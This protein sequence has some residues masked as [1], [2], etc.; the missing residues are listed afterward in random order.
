MSNSN[1][2]NQYNTYARA[3]GGNGYYNPSDQAQEYQSSDYADY[4]GTTFNNSSPNDSPQLYDAGMYNQ[5]PYSGGHGH[6]HGHG[7]QGLQNGHGRVNSGGSRRGPMSAYHLWQHQHEQNMRQQHAAQQM[8]QQY[9]Q[10]HTPLQHGNN[11]HFTGH[12]LNTGYGSGD[13]S[14]STP[15][16]S[17]ADMHRHGAQ[18]EQ[19]QVGG[20][21]AYV[22]HNEHWDEQLRLYEV[23]QQRHHTATALQCPNQVA[24]LPQKTVLYVD[25][26]EKSAD[27]S[28]ASERPSNKATVVQE[29]KGLSLDGHGYISL[30]S[31]IFNYKHL[32]ELFIGSNKLLAIPP[33]IGTLR[34]LRV[35]DLSTNNVSELP[36]EL[37]MCTH[38]EKLYFFDNNIRTLP[39]EL[40]SLSELQMLGVQGNPLDPALKQMIIDSGTKALIIHLRENSPSK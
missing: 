38:L 7:T 14:N 9:A 32:H 11:M 35:L 6:G 4:T 36:A 21:R 5:N 8:Q 1:Q 3:G 27:D 12:H 19:Q 33:T 22:Q 24:R 34:N 30:S 20:G 16:Y 31:A 13:I 29:W 25:N 39:R 15:S 10:E 17:P 37:G 28:F 18:Q 40:G 23:C 26:T 2:Y